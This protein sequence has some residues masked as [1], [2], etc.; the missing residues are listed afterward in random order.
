MQRPYVF[1]KRALITFKAAGLRSP[2]YGSAEEE[3]WLQLWVE[4]YG[5]LEPELFISC[6][7]VLAAGRY[8]P[9]LHDMNAAVQDAQKKLELARRREQEA[10]AASAGP[11]LFD[12]E[13][14]KRR[15]RELIEHL[16]RRMTP[17]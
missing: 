3:Y 9:R 5:E 15:M 6:V 11:D 17:A 14:N 4:R 7:K 12:M 2:L 8:F 10:A 1:M 13:K 16:E